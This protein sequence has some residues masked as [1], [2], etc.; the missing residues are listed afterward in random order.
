MGIS[1]NFDSNNQTP[2]VEKELNNRNDQ[3]LDEM[4]DDDYEEG[5][6]N[7][8]MVQRPLYSSGITTNVS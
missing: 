6:V 4:T 2:V 5:E 7:G 3:Y 1:R 8:F